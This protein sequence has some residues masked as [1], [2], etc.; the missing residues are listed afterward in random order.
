MGSS[1]SKLGL[2]TPLNTQDVYN[3]SK[4]DVLDK[5]FH[6]LKKI[7]YSINVQEEICKSL[8]QKN[9]SHTVHEVWL[10]TDSSQEYLDR[11]TELYTT[12]ISHLNYI[13]NVKID[14]VKDSNGAMHNI[15]LVVA[16]A[17]SSKQ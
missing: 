4:Q 3:S 12:F 16:V 1:S 10:S 14:V 2:H 13:K 5:Y 6:E 17:V 15:K 9:S 11:H 8:K 7:L